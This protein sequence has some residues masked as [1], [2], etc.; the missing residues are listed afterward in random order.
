MIREQWY[1]VL[2]SKEVGKKP[3][4]VTRMGEHLVFWREENQTIHC[5]ADR[6][7][8]RGVS[9]S[10]GKVTENHLQCPF[11]GLEYDRDGRCVYIPAN[12]RGGRIP[13]SLYLSTYPAFEDQG[14][15]WI[16]W[17]KSQPYPDQPLFF[18]NIDGSFVYSS[19]PDFWKAHYSRAIENQLDVVHLPFV[20][21]N[22]IGRGNNT[23]VD[24]PL[25]KWEGEQ[26]LFTY[27]FN[28]P[29]TGAPPRKPNQL[30][31]NEA[32]SVH[33]ELIMPNLWQ[34]Y[35]SDD[36]RIV[37]AFAPVDAFNTILYLRFYQR[38]FRFPLLDRFI[39]TLA[40]PSNL[41]IAHQDRRVVETH[42]V[43]PSS[44]KSDEKLIQGDLPII[45]YRKKRAALKEQA[46]L[47]FK[48]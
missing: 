28:R 45:E 7:P 21:H 10:I 44:L 42:Q 4:G 48:E 13:D 6:C 25:V 8:H 17:G 9:L 20:H 34:N 47:I 46:G 38:F 36:V 29:D 35:I 41:F 32:R 16:W 11:H 19:K 33:L 43:Q 1:V 31:I 30:N 2:D 24:G 5:A 39:T 14:L 12:G 26:K 15:I 23:V 27:V 18:D 37:I 22:T 3:I 40:M